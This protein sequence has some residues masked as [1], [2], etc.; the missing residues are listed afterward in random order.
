MVSNYKNKK[1][2]Y[3]PKKIKIRNFR[4][5]SKL[6]LENAIIFNENLNTIFNHKDPDT[7]A[8]IFQMEMN[9]IIDHL[10]PLK[11]VNF[12]KNYAPYL[13]YELNNQIKNTNKLLTTAI[14]NKSQDDL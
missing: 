1:I 10:A 13:T 7:I 6:K 12:K 9:N 2:K 4:N 14:N 11:V 5:L 3:Q 8:N